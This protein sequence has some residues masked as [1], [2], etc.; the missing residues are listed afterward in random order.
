[1]VITFIFVFF[2]GC[3]TGRILFF[4]CLICF[5]PERHNKYFQC[6][7]EMYDKYKEYNKYREKNPEKKELDR[8]HSKIRQCTRDNKGNEEKK[9]TKKDNSEIEEEIGEVEACGDTNI[10]HCHARRCRE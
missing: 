6:R 7:I 2:V 9:S 10:S 1:M 8:G 5:I 3:F 4:V